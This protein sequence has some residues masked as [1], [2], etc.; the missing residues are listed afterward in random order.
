MGGLQQLSQRL[1]HSG[2]P[3]SNVYNPHIVPKTGVDGNH[4]RSLHAEHE[5]ATYT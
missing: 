2:I 4:S 5:V 1:L 3:G